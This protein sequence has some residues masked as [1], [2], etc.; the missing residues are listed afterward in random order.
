MDKVKEFNISIVYNEKSN[1]L[2]F[3]NNQEKYFINYLVYDLDDLKT[4]MEFITN[5]LNNKK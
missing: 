4:V 5:H 2:K 1:N 3:I